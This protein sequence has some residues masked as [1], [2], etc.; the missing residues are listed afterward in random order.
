MLIKRRMDLRLVPISMTLNDR[1]HNVTLYIAISGARCAEVNENRP[2]FSAAW[3]NSGLKIKVMQGHT[4][5]GGHA[6]LP[7]IGR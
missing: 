4:P 7:D 3:I 1:K 2:M 5:E 6:H